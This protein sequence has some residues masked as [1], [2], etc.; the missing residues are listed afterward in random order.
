VDPP[1]PPGKE[2]GRKA[3]QQL[4]S[5]RGDH[6][7][8]CSRGERRG[9]RGRGSYTVVPTLRRFPHPAQ[10]EKKGERDSTS[11]PRPCADKSLI[12][13]L[14]G[15]GGRRGKGGRSVAGYFSGWGELADQKKKAAHLAVVPIL[16][17][18]PP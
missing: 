11:P 3:P 14:A 12:I 13:G 9:K 6:L 15:R 5:R 1:L 4:A 16:V 2:K 7:V 17:L 10:R 8:L 18:S